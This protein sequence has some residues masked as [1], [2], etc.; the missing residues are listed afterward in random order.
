MS[1]LIGS[2]EPVEPDPIAVLFS[3]AL[4]GASATLVLWAIWKLIC[5]LFLA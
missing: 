2:E 5:R 3:L 4:V 1:D